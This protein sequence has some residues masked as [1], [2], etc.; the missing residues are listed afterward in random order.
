VEGGGARVP[1]DS[2]VLNFRVFALHAGPWP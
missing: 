1:N 2:R